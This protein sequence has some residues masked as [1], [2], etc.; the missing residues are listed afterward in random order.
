MKRIISFAVLA[1]LIFAPN[2]QAFETIPGIGKNPATTFKWTVTPGVP[3]PYAIHVSGTADVGGTGERGQVKLGLVKWN[4]FT[5]LKFVFTGTTTSVA[6]LDLKNGVIFDGANFS[7]GSSVLA[8][9]NAAVFSNAPQVR[10]EGDLH[11][12]DRDF[13]WTLGRTNVG[14]TGWTLGGTNAQLLQVYKI[15]PVAAHE[16]GHSVGLGHTAVYDGTM[17]FQN[18]GDDRGGTLHA[19]DIAGIKWLYNPRQNTL[20][21]PRLITP[22]N[23]T[24]HRVL[25][26]TGT[27]AASGITFRW[28]QNPTLTLTA[29]FLEFAADAN[30][31]RNFRRFPAGLK[32]A[33]FMGKGAKLNAL[34]T[35][36][37]A[38]PT[39]TI[40]W[41]VSAKSPTGAT[42]RSSVFTF[43]LVPQ[44]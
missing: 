25:V 20:S 24:A 41:R 29:F 34:K 28:E 38:S 39:G 19:D 36:Q 26:G 4:P 23:N 35:I 3:I 1:I 12:N 31:T 5:P 11:F 13:K 30:F 8:F 6:S 32:L 42:V 40:F 15:L 27:Q 33:L 37:N 16:F 9:M 21:V 44:A 2:N 7:Q 43:S 14:L 22:L 10:V 18:Q 17:F